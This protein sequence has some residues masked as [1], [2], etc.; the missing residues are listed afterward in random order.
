MNAAPSSALRS[1]LPAAGPTK[2]LFFQKSEGASNSA[3]TKQTPSIQKSFNEI[4]LIVEL[5][6]LFCLVELNCIIT[7]YH[8][9]LINIKLKKINGINDS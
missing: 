1:L 5:L 9:L 8:L 3:T 2:L 4:E 7:V 6:S